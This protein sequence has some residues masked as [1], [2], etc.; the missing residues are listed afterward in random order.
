MED[1]VSSLRVLVMKMNI[2]TSLDYG[3]LTKIIQRIQV[4]FASKAFTLALLTRI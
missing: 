3:V 2:E 4:T 1:S